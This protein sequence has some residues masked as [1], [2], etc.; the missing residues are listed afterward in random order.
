MYA[1]T[2]IHIY[3]YIYIYMKQSNGADVECHHFH[4]T[5]EKV[6]EFKGSSNER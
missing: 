1:Y 4:I 3:I 6:L 2:Y 5:N